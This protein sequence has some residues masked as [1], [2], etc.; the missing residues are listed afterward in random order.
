[1]RYLWK[2]PTDLEAAAGYRV[3]VQS[4]TDT[5][6][7]DLSDAPFTLAAAPL[8]VTF[9]DLHDELLI[10]APYAVTWTCNDLDAVGPD[11]RIG[12]HKGGAFVDWMT[13]RTENDGLWNWPVPEGLSPAPS[14][15]LRLQSYTD[16]N[17][18][19]MSPAFGISAAPE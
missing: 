4:Y 16:K 12:L 7:K 10:G 14:Y 6:I 8:L 5:A 2:I 18:R 9:P 13:R 1:K 17:L 15:R 19:T 3:R 11:V